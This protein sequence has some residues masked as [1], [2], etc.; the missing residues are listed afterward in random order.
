MNAK[1]YFSK[2]IF[3]VHAG[4]TPTEVSSFSRIDTHQKSVL[5]TAFSQKLYLNKTTV[6]QLVQET[7]LSK[8]K[9]INWFSYKR[10]ILWRQKRKG[11]LSMGEY[12][13]I[14]DMHI[15]V[16]FYGG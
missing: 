6:E 11:A 5:E 9:V 4:I 8:G 2:L 3:A 10:K 15:I 7:G 16:G 12:L 14:I 13:Y 1:E